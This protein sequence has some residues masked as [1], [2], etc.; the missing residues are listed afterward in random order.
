MTAWRILVE[1]REEKPLVKTSRKW[2]IM[3]GGEWTPESFAPPQDGRGSRC[4]VDTGPG[5]RARRANKA[6]ATSLVS[7][8]H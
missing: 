8:K 5:V 6:T 4:G 2:D 3:F 1:R 7:G